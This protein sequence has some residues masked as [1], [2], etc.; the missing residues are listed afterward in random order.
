MIDCVY[1]LAPAFTWYTDEKKDQQ[2]KKREVQK[3]NHVDALLNEV[4]LT[5]RTPE[6]QGEKKRFL[7][8]VKRGNSE[9]FV[10][11]LDAEQK[12][13]DDAE[14]K[15]ANN[16]EIVGCNFDELLYGKQNFQP[17]EDSPAD[18][19]EITGYENDFMGDPDLSGVKQKKAATTSYRLNVMFEPHL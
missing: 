12:D 7:V 4:G 10:E 14:Q 1:A 13:P 18:E 3:R 6:C 15:D 5:D 11:I 17:E 8:V 16:A 2:R 9:Q 19:E